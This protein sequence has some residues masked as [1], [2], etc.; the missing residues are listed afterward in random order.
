MLRK[1]SVTDVWHGFAGMQWCARM[2]V[3]ELLTE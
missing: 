3:R 1:F 2:T